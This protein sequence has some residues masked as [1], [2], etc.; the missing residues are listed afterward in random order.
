[1]LRTVLAGL[2]FCASYAQASDGDYIKYL[3]SLMRNEVNAGNIVDNCLDPYNPSMWEY[4][5]SLLLNDAKK[6]FTE[7]KP[8]TRVA[9]QFVIGNNKIIMVANV[10]EGNGCCAFFSKFGT[11]V[12]SVCGS[13]SSSWKIT[14]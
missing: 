11:Y 9:T 6:Y 7:A 1:M 8:E 14:K 10:A 13:E 5:K 2:V 4:P 3:D 12:N